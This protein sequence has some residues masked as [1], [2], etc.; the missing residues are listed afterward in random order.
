MA[1]RTFILIPWSTV[2]TWAGDQ[3]SRKMTSNYMTVS[4]WRLLLPHSQT[5]LRP[6]IWSVEYGELQVRKVRF[7]LH[8]SP[9]KTDFEKVY[10]QPQVEGTFPSRLCYTIFFRLS[11]NLKELLAPSRFKTAE[12]GQTNSCFLTSITNSF[13][14]QWGRLWMRDKANF[15][16]NLHFR[17]CENLFETNHAFC[18]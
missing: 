2:S 10:T 13:S 18:F 6:K 9:T 12:K 7:P 8:W 1:S 3:V 17:S 16:P 5:H 4:D 11:K 15:H 14:L